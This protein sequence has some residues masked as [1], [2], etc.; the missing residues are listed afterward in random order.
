MS[1]QKFKLLDDQNTLVVVGGQFEGQYEATRQD[2]CASCS[3]WVN[4]ICELKT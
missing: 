2:G 4:E 3:F 1:E